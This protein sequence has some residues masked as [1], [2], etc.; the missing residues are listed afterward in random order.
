MNTTIRL[1]LTEADFDRVIDGALTGHC[2]K[3]NPRA[4]TREDYRAVLRQSTVA[5]S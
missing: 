5:L 3:T 1:G 4:A 2:H